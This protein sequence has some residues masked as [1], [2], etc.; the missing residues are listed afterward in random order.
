MSSDIDNYTV[1]VEDHLDAFIVQVNTLIDDSWRPTGGISMTVDRHFMQALVR[2]ALP[3]GMKRYP[4]HTASVPASVPASKDDVSP[5]TD[6][7]DQP[8]LKPT[9]QEP[10]S[11]AKAG[12]GS[13]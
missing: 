1:V 12:Y 8:V 7:V 4:K 5:V 2:P 10:H 3:I 13:V 6:T 9:R 11:T